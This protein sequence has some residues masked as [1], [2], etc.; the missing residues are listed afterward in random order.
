MLSLEDLNLPPVLRDVCR[1]QR[2]LVVI[3]GGPGQGKSTTAAAMLS[4]CD[5][6]S[7]GLGV[8]VANSPGATVIDEICDRQTMEQAIGLSKAGRLCIATL[9][10]E[11]VSSALERIL[12]FFPDDQ[13]AQILAE[14]GRNV[15]VLIAQRLIPMKNGEERIPAVGIL[16]GTP[17]IQELFFAD[18]LGEM[19]GI[20]AKSHLGMQTSDQHLVDLYERGRIGYDT[21]L[22]NGDSVSEVALMIKNN[23]WAGSFPPLWKDFV[24]ELTRDARWPWQ[25]GPSPCD[26]GAALQRLLDEAGESAWRPLTIAL[27]VGD[28]DPLSRSLR[29]WAC[30]GLTQLGTRAAEAAGDLE[31]FVRARRDPREDAMAALAAVDPVRARAIAWPPDA[32]P[33]LDI[34]VDGLSAKDG[35]LIDFLTGGPFPEKIS[36]RHLD[37]AIVVSASGRVDMRGDL[38][39]RVKRL[40]PHAAKHGKVVVFDL[41]AW[42]YCDSGWG[43]IMVAVKGAKA[44]GV[45]IAAVTPQ[46]RA[47]K[48]R[49]EMSK[50]ELAIR[51]YPSVDSA[52]T[53]LASDT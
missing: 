29:R 44:A 35:S 6:N 15:E 1:M 10:A 13:R 33:P 48:E 25:S 12:G 3:A 27:R 31:A 16:V 11:S 50:M 23:R 32:M 51:C 9:H 4:H 40:I 49:F 46:Q 28:D 41:S 22:R 26:P 43:A 34:R 37:R 53:A 18:R 45:A 42:M 36:E 52:L 24:F 30:F 38:Y 17:Q 7:G 39:Q 21:A 19:R 8:V 5:S 2:G 47:M 14:L 20:M